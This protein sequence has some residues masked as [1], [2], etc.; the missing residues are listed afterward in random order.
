[1]ENSIGTRWIFKRTNGAISKMSGSI[2][3]K[4]GEIKLIIVQKPRKLEELFTKW[5][6]SMLM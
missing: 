6:F 3:E 1:L 2:I 5:N 4:M